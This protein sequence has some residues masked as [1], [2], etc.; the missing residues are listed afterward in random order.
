MEDGP[1]LRG[2]IPASFYPPIHPARRALPIG[3]LAATSS[4]PPLPPQ[5]YRCEAAAERERRDLL[6]PAWCPV[7]TADQLAEP[8]QYVAAEVAGV[9]VVVRNFG[10]EGVVAVR[11][12]CAHRACTMLGDGP[13]RADRLRC[14]YHGWEY[15]PDGRTRKIHGAKNFPKFDREAHRLDRYA[16]DRLGDLWFVRA[17]ESGP[18]LREF[19][20]DPFDH[21]AEH[22]SAPTWRPT[23]RETIAYEANWKIP[24]EGSLESYHVPAVHPNTFGV[25]PGDANSEHVLKP[26]YTAFFSSFRQP[27]LLTAAED[28][29][30]RRLGQEPT[31]RYEHW[32]VFPNLMFTVMDSLTL[33]MSVQPGADPRSSRAVLFQF[34][35][36]ARGRNPVARA[37]AAALGRIAANAS[38]TVLKEDQPLFPKVQRGLD[39]TAG[40]TIYGRCEERLQA[41]GEWVAARSGGA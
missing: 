20:G 36:Q 16:V 22:L 40:K 30:L 7:A 26:D 18:S 12:V 13:G 23:L 17:G 15:G 27:S 5:A 9:P 32:H 3:Y 33:A 39:A 31:G 28:W 4:T 25:D 35:R 14:P 10:R 8:G 41:F 11:N 38:L 21:L 1:R 29:A 34:G 2:L 19:V 6:M 37:T 24:I